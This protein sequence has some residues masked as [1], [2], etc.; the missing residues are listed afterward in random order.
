[1]DPNLG[2]V[3]CLIAGAIIAALLLVIL[4]ERGDES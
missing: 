1:M 3:G 4:G 2:S